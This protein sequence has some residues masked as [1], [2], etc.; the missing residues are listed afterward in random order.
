MNQDNLEGSAK[1]GF[2]KLESVAGDALGDG[3]MQAKGDARQ[4]EGKAQDLMGSAQDT[5]GQVADQAKAAVSKVTDQAKD[6]YAR[7]SDT[8]QSVR[9]QVEPFV[10]DRPYAA[11][12]VAAA[13]G[14]LVGLLLA[15]RGPKIVYVRPHN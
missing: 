14:L 3:H 8:A 10:E 6:V 7:A 15:S 9:S 1:A 4:F 12:G 13:V 11:L 2:G 5:V